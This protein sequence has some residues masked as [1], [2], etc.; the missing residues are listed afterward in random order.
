MPKPRDYHLSEE[1]LI[2]IETAIR[3]DKRPEV[4][5]RCTAIRLL[6]LDHKPEQVAEMQAVSKPTIY[7]WID[8]WR[9]GGVEGLANRPKSG[10][11]L[12]ADD[13]YSL[14]L[15][16]VIEKEP[17]ELGYDFTIWTIDRLRA[18]LEKIT[19]IDLSESRFRAL[20]KRKGY[21]YR[22]PKQDLG[23]LQDKN[24]K[25]EA[26]DRL[27]ELKKSPRRRFQAHLYGRNNCN[28]GSTAAS[29]LDED[30]AA[31]TYSSDQTRRKAEATHLWRLQL[32]GR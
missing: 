31:E 19:G 11:P 3:H 21:R 15:L 28:A 25:A 29:L 10:R 2:V 6:H 8:R 1:E 18:H 5:Q 14:A 24:A 30:W 9:S 4:R 27:E 13:A 17:S 22:R 16:E 12:K 20:L 26:A 7:G 23:H 32:A